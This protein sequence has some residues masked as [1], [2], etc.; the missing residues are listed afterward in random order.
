MRTVAFWGMIQSDTLK[1]VESRA[2]QMAVE[3]PLPVASA[4]ALETLADSFHNRQNS[5]AA[6]YSWQPDLTKLAQ[7][8]PWV[9]WD[10]PEDQTPP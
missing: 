3:I 2:I 8:F 1:P 9:D 6:C 7:P 4:F 10:L 5:T